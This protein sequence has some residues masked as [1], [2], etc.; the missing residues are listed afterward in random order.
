MD[1]HL[2]VLSD[3]DFHKIRTMMADFSGIQMAD[4]KKALVAGRLMKRLKALRLGSFH[5]Y[6]VLLQS[7]AHQEERRLAIDLLTTN[8]TFFFREKS[9]FDYLLNLLQKNP[10]RPTRIW[11]AAC[12][13]GEEVY[14]LAMTLQEG[15]S[16]HTAWDVVGSD[17]ARPVLE[18]AERAI[19]P[20]QQSSQI[21]HDWLVRYCLRG[22]QQQDGFFCIQPSLT[23]HV[24]FRCINLNQ[25][26]PE[27]IGMF[28]I[29]FLRN[30]LI[31][32]DFQ[33][34]QAI[35]TRILTRLKPGG[36]LFVSHS[37]GLHGLKLPV[38]PFAN[39]VY[40]KQL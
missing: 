32:F 17:I 27:E 20:M 6:V 37:E 39:A 21:P 18:K 7:P 30:M 8:E 14:S 24:S 13:S 33:A 22:I 23:Q 31:Y 4:H 40:R 36:L 26:I 10:T 5:D 19:Y 3:Q 34:K 16:H 11:S 15:L 12:S 28:D 25:P 35:L 29:I 9:H 38:T 1:I 2:P